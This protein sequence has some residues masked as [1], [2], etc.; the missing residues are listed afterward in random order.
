MV[1]Y[2]AKRKRE[3]LWINMFKKHTNKSTTFARISPFSH[4]TTSAEKTTSA[5]QSFPSKRQTNL[6]RTTISI[7]R[8]DKSTTMTHHKY[9]V[10]V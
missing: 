5:G 1:A 4:S 3:K 9:E 10:I 6:Y 7:F 8:C 2:K